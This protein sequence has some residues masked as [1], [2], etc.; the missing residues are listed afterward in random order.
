MA[1]TSP[2]DRV[3]AVV[4]RLM[5]PPVFVLIGVYAVGILVMAMLPGQDADGNPTRMSLFHAFYF[6]TYTAT[7]TGFGE[8]P[9]TFTDEQRLWAIFCVYM[10]A[11]A[12]LYAIGSIIKLVQNPHF[13]N[14]VSERRFA[15]AAHGIKEPFYIICGFGDTGSLL[16]RGLS[17]NYVTAVVIDID[18]ERIKALALRDYRVPMPGLCADASVP[19]HLLG[20]GIKSPSCLGVVALTND[21]ETNLKIAVMTRTLNPTLPVITRS[22]SLRYQRLLESMDQVTVINPFQLF[23]EQLSITI[24]APRLRMLEDWFVCARGVTLTRSLR[25]P[26]G[27]WFLCGYGRMGRWIYRYLSDHHVPLVVIDPHP[28]EAH[29]DEVVMR[30][31]P[32]P[33]MLDKNGFRQAAGIVCGTH[34]DA[35]NLAILLSARGL[36]RE[37]FAIVRQNHHENHVAFSGARADMTMQP[38]LVTARKILLM[39]IAPLAE[40]LLQELEARGEDYTQKTV[41]ALIAAVGPERPILWRQRLDPQQTFAVARRLGR[42][43]QVHLGDV[44]TDPRDSERRL[45]CVA[46]AISRRGR[47]WTMPDDD[48]P[49]Q[50]G[51]ELLFCSTSLGRRLLEATLNN[52]YTLHYLTTGEELP[53]GYFFTW[54]ARRRKQA[55]PAA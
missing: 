32:D 42:N 18:E 50:M 45:P 40:D 12:W 5:R 3:T 47:S 23:A 46:L 2:L 30:A 26:L 33:E 37:A 53:R 44:L 6:F 13:L 4:L 34:S 28:P 19:K 24:T 11:I 36:N 51:D 52:A 31:Y 8:I 7:T 16:A 25:I 9:H 54:L 22:T 43:K 1:M 55:R 49:L 35:E 48:C 17:D 29:Q 27:T 10:G 21:E 14:A 38:S 39:L 15:S 41:D 20:A